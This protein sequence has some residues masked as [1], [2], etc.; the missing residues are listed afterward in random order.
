MSGDITKCDCDSV[1]VGCRID[2]ILD[3]AIA[4]L[5][6]I[7]EQHCKWE[8]DVVIAIEFVNCINFMDDIVWTVIKH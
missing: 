4:I 2:E 3:L 5:F 8:V 6:Q 7:S 1:L